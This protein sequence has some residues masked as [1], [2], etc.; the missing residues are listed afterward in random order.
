MVFNAAAINQLR[1]WEFSQL[2]G[3]EG[4]VSSSSCTLRERPP[5][6]QRRH[7]LMDRF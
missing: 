2:V 3:A 7:L 5:R 6:M 4:V 1:P